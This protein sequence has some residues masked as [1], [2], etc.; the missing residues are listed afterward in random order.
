M[1]GLPEVSWPLRPERVRRIPERKPIRFF[2]QKRGQRVLLTGKLAPAG[3]ERLFQADKVSSG[4]VKRHAV[5]TMV[6]FE[7]VCGLI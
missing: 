6:H 3:R 2:M 1:P 5:M 4:G 7:C